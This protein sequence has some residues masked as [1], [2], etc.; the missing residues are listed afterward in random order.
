MFRSRSIGKINLRY[1]G[2]EDSPATYFANL[3]RSAGDA[4]PRTSLR[5]SRCS[6]SPENAPRPLGRTACGTV[7]TV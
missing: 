3:V 7:S 6:S 2:V 5:H 4:E 1:S